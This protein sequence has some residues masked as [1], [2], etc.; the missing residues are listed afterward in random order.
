MRTFS[1]KISIP[2]LQAIIASKF[3]EQGNDLHVQP[4][5][6]KNALSFLKRNY[7][8]TG[9]V[10]PQI[11]K[12][13]AKVDFSEENLDWENGYAGTKSFVGF[14]T[15][16][17]GLTYFGVSCGGDWET[18]LVY[19]VYWDGRQ[20]RGYVPED[21]NFWNTDTKAAYGNAYDYRNH[22][23]MDAANVKKRFG[24]ESRD[25]LKDMDC[26]S[27]IADIQKHIVYIPKPSRSLKQF[28]EQ[29]S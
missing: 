19:I 3:I 28:T 12:D 29:W 9:Q 8:S 22:I 11:M 17:N 16:P 23:D 20:L 6:C 26:K 21:G 18:P 27:I 13:L 15:L 10:T 2:D 5:K 24:V 25:D 4:D 1:V 7:L 14:H